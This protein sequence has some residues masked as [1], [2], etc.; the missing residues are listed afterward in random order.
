VEDDGIVNTLAGLLAVA[1]I[2]AIAVRAGPGKRL[3]DN[4]QEDDGLLHNQ[5]AVA[6]LHLQGNHLTDQLALVIQRVIT[7]LFRQRVFTGAA[8]LPNNE[9]AAYARLTNIIDAQ[10]PAGRRL[11][12]EIINACGGAV[13]V[14][15]DNDPE[16][17]DPLE[18]QTLFRRQVAALL[19]RICIHSNRNRPLNGNP[20]REG[21]SIAEIVAWCMA[22]GE[23][24]QVQGLNLG[25]V[26]EQ[27]AIPT[28]T[29]GEI[30][31][32]MRLLFNGGW[33]NDND[34]DPLLHPSE[35]CYNEAVRINETLI[36]NINIGEFV[37]TDNSIVTGY[38]IPDENLQLN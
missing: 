22:N 38:V 11:V 30:G 4:Q 7:N 9:G 25:V 16:E 36:F 8:L 24:P 20:D 29:N 23:I 17:G 33:A 2:F 31:E 5:A 15:E 18:V 37:V 14:D 10:I 26:P 1:G 35:I 3:V 19:F 13:E 34:N 6:G 28:L 32:I 27:L 21:S 12:E